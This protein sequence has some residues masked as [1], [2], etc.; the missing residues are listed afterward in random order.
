MTTNNNG[1]KNEKHSVLAAIL[2]VDWFAVAKPFA[3]LAIIAGSTGAF[4]VNRGVIPHPKEWTWP[5][6]GERGDSSD[7]ALDSTA[8]TI[9]EDPNSLYILKRFEFYYIEDY[10]LDTVVAVEGSVGEPLA[11]LVYIVSDEHGRLFWL[12]IV[13][14]DPD[15]RDV[16]LFLFDSVTVSPGQGVNGWEQVLIIPSYREEF[17]GSL[18]A[19]DVASAGWA[20]RDGC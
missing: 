3:I 11:W 18:Y 6:S 16:R 7:I 10:C 5:L 19:W 2:E 13:A 8:D 15:L 17:T 1:E 12:L 4:L 20:C 9:S 14:Y